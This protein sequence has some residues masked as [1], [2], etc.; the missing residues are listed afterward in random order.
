VASDNTQ[1]VSML[2][3]FERYGQ[4]VLQLK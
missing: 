1:D 3:A 4:T 2:L